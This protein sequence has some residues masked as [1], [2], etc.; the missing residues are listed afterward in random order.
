MIS[1]GLLDAVARILLLNAARAFPVKEKSLSTDGAMNIRGT[2]GG[3]AK[4]LHLNSLFAVL[5]LLASFRPVVIIYA[6]AFSQ[7]GQSRILA[8]TCVVCRISTYSETRSIDPLCVS[9]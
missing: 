1:E 7:N 4:D 2:I 6:A 9:V 3:F 5:E 8:T